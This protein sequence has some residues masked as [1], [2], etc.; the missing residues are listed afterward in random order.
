[1]KM[2][3]NLYE[4]M[5]WYL[6]PQVE[7]KHNFQSLCK[8]LNHD[9]IVSNEYIKPWRFT[10]D[11]QIWKSKCFTSDAWIT[12]QYFIPFLNLNIRNQSEEKEKRVE[13]ELTFHIFHNYTYYLQLIHQLERKLEDNLVKSMV[14]PKDLLLKN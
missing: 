9:E 3:K 13:E 6:N 10:I 7:M 8:S 2:K 1:M 4:Q 11:K 14:V 5:V 12:R